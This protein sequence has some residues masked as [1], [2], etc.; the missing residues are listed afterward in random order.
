V[1]RAPLGYFQLRTGS[2]LCPRGLETSRRDDCQI[3]GRGVGNGFG[4]GASGTVRFTSG[5]VREMIEIVATKPRNM[6]N[7]FMGLCGSAVVVGT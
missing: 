1:E 5:G 6:K 4:V 7:A 2:V 3:V